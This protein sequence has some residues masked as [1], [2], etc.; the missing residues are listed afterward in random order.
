MTRLHAATPL[1]CVAAIALFAAPRV[2]A[3]QQDQTPAPQPVATPARPA[4]QSQERRTL[5]QQLQQRMGQVVR[6]RLQLT[7]TQFAQLQAVN[8][9]YAGRR[10]QLLQRERGL[11]QQLR[12]Q[13]LR[14]DQADQATVG[15]LLD[16]IMTLQET[17]LALTRQE[18]RD[19]TSFL[20]PVQRA[21][22]AAIEEQVHRR[23]ADLR[24]QRQ[25]RQQQRGTRPPRR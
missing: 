2:H 5:E 20:T 17:R 1:V 18:Q 6:K 4:A 8:Q 14:G 19:L 25:Q 9:R 11:R 13:V 7:D 12:Q 10:A 22:Y 15:T 16:Q 24:R 21:R 3:Q 23:I